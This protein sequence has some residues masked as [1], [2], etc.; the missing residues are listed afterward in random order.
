MIKDANTNETQHSL[1]ITAGQ[2]KMSL[3]QYHISKVLEC[4]VLFGN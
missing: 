3:S 4:K 2:K 1:Q